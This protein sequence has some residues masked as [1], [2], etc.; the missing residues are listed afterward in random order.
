M[1]RPDR[2]IIQA[3]QEKYP[4]EEI[5]RLIDKSLELAQQPGRES[6]KAILEIVKLLL[7]YT[8]GQPVQRTVTFTTKFEDMLREVVG[9]P[10][11][12]RDD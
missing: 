1:N 12:S 11:E 9:E 8:V 7:A 5:V 2:A 10:I 3:I 6:S 4:A